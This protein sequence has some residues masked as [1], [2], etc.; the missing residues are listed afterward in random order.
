HF[1]DLTD[2]CRRS[3]NPVGRIMLAL[4]GKTDAVCVAQSDGICTALQL[5]NFWQDVAV[6]WQKGRVYIPQDDLLKFGVSEEQIAAGRADA[7]FQ[8]L[9]A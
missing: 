6:D 7:A 8:R 2:Y 3:A 9:M 1:G 5:V 4:Y